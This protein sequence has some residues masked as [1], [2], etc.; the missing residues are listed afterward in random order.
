MTDGGIRM[1]SVPPASS[2]PQAIFGSY[3]RF[4]IAGSAIIPIV[5]SVAPTT[6]TIAASTVQAS[7]VAEAR[8]PLSAPSHL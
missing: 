7:T 8:P 6:P 3:W 5:T 2:A 4:S 1:P